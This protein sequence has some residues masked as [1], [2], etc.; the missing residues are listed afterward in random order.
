MRVL[1]QNPGNRNIKILLLNKEN[2]MSQVNEFSTF[3]WMGGCKSAPIE[4]IHLIWAS[5]L[6]VYSLNPLTVHHWGWL[7]GL[8]A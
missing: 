4:I 5:L 7:Q 6:F 3:L 8:L 1:Q 2:Q